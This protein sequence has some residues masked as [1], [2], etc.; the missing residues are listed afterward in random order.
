MIWVRPRAIIAATVI[1]LSAIAAE[2][3]ERRVALIFGNDSYKT[4]PKLHNAAADARAIDAKLKALGWETVLRVNVTKREMNR[5]I[6]EFGN[7]LQGIDGAGLFFYAGH[8]I[9][10]EGKNFLVPVDAELE[11]AVDLRT[12]AI[13]AGLVSHAMDDNRSRVNIV[14]LDAC[15]DNP[16]PNR[17]RSATRGLAIA[18]KSPGGPRGAVVVYAA[19]PN[20]QAQD[21]APGGNG[22]FTGAFIKALSESDLKIEDVF[23]RTSAE[24]KSATGGKQ[25]PWITSSLQGDFYFAPPAPKAPPP[26]TAAPAASQDAGSAQVAFWNSI[27]GSDDPRMFE[28]Y[29]RQYPNGRFVGLA[30]LKIETLSAKK[31][32]PAPAQQLAALPPAKDFDVDPIDREFFATG[33]AR[34]REAPNPTSKPLALLKDGDRIQVLGQLKGQDWFMVETKDGHGFVAKGTLED[35]QAYRARKQKEAEA[36][37]EAKRRDDEARRIAAERAAGERAAAEKAATEKLAAE[38]AVAERAAAE[39]RARQEATA[40]AAQDKAAQDKAAQD[41]AA[42]EK[43]AQDEAERKKAQERQAVAALP[44][45]TAPAAAFDGVWEARGM[46]YTG[47][48]PNARNCDQVR[49]V[50][51]IDG[52]YVRGEN[53]SGF[54]NFYFDGS[55]TPGGEFRTEY[56]LP[57]GSGAVLKGTLP[58]LFFTGRNCLGQ[59]TFQKKATKG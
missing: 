54:G 48:D 40:K 47:A 56:R 1:C 30:K 36:A 13:D 4:L 50:L 45:Q 28:E 43:V 9:Q 24:V 2:A 42:Q 26:A 58:G 57:G 15:R 12:D 52:G 38:R 31:P 8:G 6:D 14:I 3:Q 19:A 23:K 41:K 22:V 35:G 34:V 27:A 5:A 7:K 39:E 53:I 17:G 49:V 20:Q 10:A 37:A 16:L 29:L 51:T 21:G 32:A 18:E 55:V 25:V 33:A 46:R 59:M 44:P 11:T